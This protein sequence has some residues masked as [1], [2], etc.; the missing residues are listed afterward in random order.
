MAKKGNYTINPLYQGGY[1]TLDPNKYSSYGDLFTGYHVPA[2]AIG[3]P[4]SAQTA[5]QIQQANNLMNQGIIPIEVGA[6]KPEVFDQIPKQHFKEINRMAKLTGSDISVHSPIIEASGI[7][8]QGYDE[9]QRKQAEQQLMDVVERTAPMNEKGGMRITIHGAGSIPGTDY[10]MQ[11][12]KKKEERLVVVNRDTGKIT[13]ALKEEEKYYP[14]Q[15]EPDVLS[16]RSELETLNR[17]EW[18]NEIS[19]LSHYKE[20][21]DR[22]I[23]SHKDVLSPEMLKRVYENPEETIHML[24]PDQIDAYNNLFHAE[25]YLRDLQM[26]INNMYHKAYKMAKIDNNESA[27][28]KLDKAREKYMKMLK[29]GPPVV[30]ASQ[31]TQSMLNTLASKEI[32]PNL[33]QPIEDYA[34]EKS[35]N[36]F[37]NVALNSYKKYKD[38]APVISIENMFPGMAFSY[39]KELKDLIQESKN[40]F[41]DK[42]VSQGVMSESKAKSQADKL[43]GATL[44]VGHLNIAKK[45]GFKDKDL[46]KEMAEIAKHV[47]HVHVTDNFGY[48]DSHLPPGM[49]NVPVKE[50]MEKLEKEGKGDVTKVLETAGWFQHFKTSPLPY[51]LEA[52]GANMFAT[53]QEPYW[54]QK[55]GLS[56]GYSG[57]FGMMLPQV[58]YNTFGAGF[59]QLPSELGG[60]VQGGKGSRMSG[61]P[62]Q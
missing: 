12:G 21:A 53:G 52:L 8:E 2:G 6:I 41:V 50:I 36:T 14:Y 39:G 28:K 5:N 56:Q 48:S 23:Q 25:Q 13:T 62:M 11:E 37:S 32:Q 61:K 42:A 29:E 38:K 7:G 16:P 49:G 35:A 55:Q 30:G 19:Q 34:T 24:K 27:I 26:K 51:N 47:K 45:K 60:S 4:T 40:Q 17:S 10:T 58:N 15:K 22:I 1:S 44:D 20:N 46:V 9:G 33:Y 54:N 59:A 18:K 57:G 3:A 31:A 43:I